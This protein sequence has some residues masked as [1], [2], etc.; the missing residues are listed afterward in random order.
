MAGFVNGGR[1]GV[2][3]GG[4]GLGLGVLWSF[5][6]GVKWAFPLLVRGRCIS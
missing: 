6:Q 5:H 4:F 3:L 1:E 2:G